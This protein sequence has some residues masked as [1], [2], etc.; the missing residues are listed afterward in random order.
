MNRLPVPPRL[1][2]FDSPLP[3]DVY[4][5]SGQLLLCKGYRITRESQREVLIARGV[6]MDENLLRQSQGSSKPESTGYDPFRLWDS[7]V[8]E[9]D[10]LM[11]NIRS[12]EDFSREVIGLAGLVQELTRRSAD[13][14]LAA[15]ILTDQRRYPIVHS[16]HVAILCE[17]IASRMAWSEA[18]RLSLCCAA[19][20]MNLAMLDLQTQLCAQ[21]MAP[22]SQQR[23]D[24]ERHPQ[25]GDEMLRY[26]GVRDEI[27]LRAVREHH[28][29]VGGGGYPFGIVAPSEEAL[30]IHTTDILSAKVSPRA[31][32]APVTPQEAAKSLYIAS[33]GGE[34]NP[35]VGALIKE[36]GIFP[37]GTFVQ[38]ANG[39]TALVLRRGAAAN[40]PQVLS[41]LSGSGTSYGKPINRDT[42]IKTFEVTAV[43]PRNKVRVRFDMEQVWRSA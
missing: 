27:W 14:A 7:I 17:L 24:I 41:L 20:T 42:S 31:A 38:L 32:R 35:Y 39:E 29:R 40:A 33:G 2:I 36:V 19:M 26:A 5:Y 9:L 18:R 25:L 16:L 6:Y 8:G 22:S 13:T 37:P 15:I 23:K 3:W 28:E 11:R 12:G 30:L 43:V 1:L 4:D 10:V 34:K 21:R